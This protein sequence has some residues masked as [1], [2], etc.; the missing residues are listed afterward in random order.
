MAL[1]NKKIFYGLIFLILLCLGYGYLYKKNELFTTEADDLRLILKIVLHVTNCFDNTTNI[2]L[3]TAEQNKLNKDFIN[4]YSGPTSFLNSDQQLK[5][6]TVIKNT[7]PKYGIF[8]FLNF[9]IFLQIFNKY[10]KMHQILSNN[11]CD[12]DLNNSDYKT[13][14]KLYNDEIDNFVS[15]ITCVIQYYKKLWT[16]KQSTDTSFELSA[17][18]KTEIQTQLQCII[19]LKLPLNNTLIS[20]QQPSNFLELNGFIHTNLISFL[21]EILV[22]IVRFSTNGYCDKIELTPTDPIDETEP[23]DP[24]NKTEPTYPAKNCYNYCYR[25]RDSDDL[26]DPIKKPVMYYKLSNNSRTSC[27]PNLSGIPTPPAITPT[28]TTPS[29]TTAGTQT[30]TTPSGTQT[31][32]TPTGTTAGTP[33]A[34]TS[35]G[36]TAGTPTATTPT[37]TP[38]VTTAGTPTSTTPRVTTAGTP[39]ATTPRVTTAGT[40]TPTTTPIVTT[41]GTSTETNPPSGTRNRR[42][43][44]YENDMTHPYLSPD[45]PNGYVPVLSG[46]LPENVFDNNGYADFG[47]YQFSYL[48]SSNIELNNSKGRNNFFIPN[49]W[50]EEYK[51]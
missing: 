31:A 43:Y 28:A 22:F 51:N 44:E 27:S 40:P 26:K 3:T 33:T 35:T 39:T 34:T 1:Y 10:K 8:I 49:I 5:Y 23:T 24:N 38:R 19:R 32:T 13:F 11:Y 2:Q 16:I 42:M 9:M 47:D 37:A 48:P 41:A 12:P 29:G 30:A 36:T 21:E 20:T 46:I 18:D 7:E 25:N 45:M 50:I 4:K 14:E 15:D 17:S 6:D